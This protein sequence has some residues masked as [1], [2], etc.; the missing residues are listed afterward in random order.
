MSL[1]PDDAALSKQ[2]SEGCL[3]SC[4]GISDGLGGRVTGHQEHSLSW[5]I[6]DPQPVDTSGDF[7]IETASVMK[8]DTVAEFEQLR[9]AGA[10]V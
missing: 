1:P 9:G 2:D 4:S 6:R 3:T 8:P 5:A 7:L 10:G